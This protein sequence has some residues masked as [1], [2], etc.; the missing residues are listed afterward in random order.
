MPAEELLPNGMMVAGAWSWRILVIAGVVAL[1][2]FLIIELRVIV[3]P[4]MISVLVS[5]LLVPFTQFLRR[6]RWPRWL[7]IVTPVVGLLAAVSGLVVLIVWQVR[8]GLPELQVQSLEAWDEFTIFMLES[9]LHLTSAQISSFG[10][11]L[12]TVVQRDSEVWLS[13]AL[14]LGSS[15]GHFIAGLFLAL[16]AT[17]LMVIDGP[18]IWRWVVR[19]FPKKAQAAVD[20][21]G[22][23][24]WGTLTEFVKVQIFVAAIDAVGIGLGA[25]ILQLP[26]VVPIAVAVFLGSFVPI[27]GAV[28]T[29]ALAVFIALIFKDAVIALIM[30]GIVLLVQ[31]VESHVLQPL[32]MGNAV[33]IHPLGVVFA[34][35]G[36]AYL[37]GIPGA[38]FAVPVVAA[39]NIMIKYIAHG[40]WRVPGGVEGAQQ[41]GRVAI[42]VP[43]DVSPRRRRASR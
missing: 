23:A 42:T 43:R 26:L 3:L 33:K 9:P 12:W 18:R 14:S 34:V 1:F 7:A 17:L 22:R 36:G 35:A 25:F 24:G 32:I 27:V 16:F 10:N 28:L 5:A 30:L 21:S 29:G 41:F 13:G 8:A 31:Q 19:L 11:E 39:L 40:A 37:A 2:V 4:L 6:H 15:A 20:G 38:L